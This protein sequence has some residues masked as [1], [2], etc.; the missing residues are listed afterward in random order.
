M[1]LGDASLY[2]LLIH[3]TN[4]YNSRSVIKGEGLNN[5]DQVIRFYNSG[6]MSYIYHW[7]IMGY[8]AN[9]PYTVF[10]ESMSAGRLWGI[11]KL[12]KSIDEIEAHL[13]ELSKD[14]QVKDKTD[15]REKTHFIFES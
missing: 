14:K 11:H 6:S 1:P 5:G 9:S 12:K 15:T 13:L 10:G 2:A 7:E 8:V 3:N 4:D